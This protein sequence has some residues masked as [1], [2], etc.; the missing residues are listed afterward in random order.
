[1]KKIKVV[2]KKSLSFMLILCMFLACFRGLELS[3]AE[4]TGNQ[5]GTGTGTETEEDKF[6]EGEYV[7]R[8]GNKN[9]SEANSEAIMLTADSAVTLMCADANGEP[10]P[11]SVP[12]GTTMTIDWS[13]TNDN[14]FMAEGK[15]VTATVNTKNGCQLTII[16]IGYDN[17]NVSIKIENAEG[18]TTLIQS[19]KICVPIR[20][21]G[22]NIKNDSPLSDGTYGLGYEFET[23]ETKG[24]LYLSG[25]E[26]LRDADPDNDKYNKYLLMLQTED[27]EYKYT[28]GAGNDVILNN[29]SKESDIENSVDLRNFLKEKITW[30]SSNNNVA[31]VEY[32][33]ITGI[34]AGV[35]VITAS[36][37]SANNDIQSVSIRVVVTPTGYLAVNGASNDYKSSFSEITVTSDFTIATNAK[38]ATDLVWNIYRVDVKNNEI[39]WSNEVSFEDSGLDVTVYSTSGDIRVRNAKAGTYHITARVSKD[40]DETNTYTPKFQ[41]YI[42]VPVTFPSAPVYMNVNDTYNIPLNAMVPSYDWFQYVSSD[43]TT[44]DVSNEGIVEALKKGEASIDVT[45]VSTPQLKEYFSNNILNDP[46]LLESVLP[47]QSTVKIKIID[48]IYLNYSSAVIYT[49]GTLT[50]KSYTTSTGQVTWS[51]ADPSIATVSESGVV[52]GINPGTVLITATQQTGELTKTAVCRITVLEGVTSITLT[53]EEAELSVGEVITINADVKPSLTGVSLHWV[54]SDPEILKILNTTDLSV[55][56]EGKSG[57]W[58]TITAINQENVVVG[59]SKIFVSEPIKSITLSQTDVMVPLSSEWLQLE[60][61]IFPDA[62]KEQEVVWTSSDKTIATVDN[63]TVVF[64]KAGIVTITVTSKEDATISASC[65]VT[66][67]KEVTGISLDNTSLSMFVGE[68]YRLQCVITPADAHELAVEWSSTNNSVA[69]VDSNGLVSAKGIGSAII[70]VRTKDGGFTATCMVE[71]GKTATAV[72]LDV[73]DLVMRVGEDYYL[74][75][76]VTP[77]DATDATLTYTTS[78]SSVVTVSKSGKV[79]AKKTG[80]A[81]ITVRTRSGSLAMCTVTVLDNVSGIK[82]G[83]SNLDIYV[84]DKFQLTY[85]ISPDNVYDSSVSWYS[86]NPSVASVDSKGVVTGKSAGQTV[87]YVTTTDGAYYATCSVT[88][89]QKVESIKMDVEKLTMNKGD[90]YYLEP[91]FT[92]KDTTETDVK[93]YIFDGSIITIS[94]NGK[95]TAKK[96]GTTLVSATAENGSI[97]Y[98]TVEVL[99]AVT[100]VQMSSSSEIIHIGDTLQLKAQVVPASATEQG[101]KWTSTDT[102]VATVDQTGLVSGI[103]GGVA[104]VICETADGGYNDFC[105]V[106]VDEKVTDI[107]LNY[108]E[109]RLGLNDTFQLEATITGERATN[110]EVQWMSA[111]KRI[112]SV[113]ENGKVRGLVKGK[114]EIICMA[115][116]G[117]GAEAVCEVEVCTLVT[118]IELDV[119]TLTLIKGKSY[120]LDANISPSNATYKTPIWTSSD[121]DIVMVDKKGVITGLEEGTAIITATADDSGKESALCY[122]TVI[123]PVVAKSISVTSSELV[124]VPGESKNVSYTV[125]PSNFTEDVSWTCD[126]TSVATVDPQTGKI[127]AKNTGI[128]NITVM[129]PSGAKATIKVYV[130]GLSRTEVTLKQYESLLIRLQIDGAEEAGVSVRWDVEDQGIAEVQGGRVTAKALGTTKVYAV[131]NGRKLECKVTVIKN[132]KK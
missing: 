26:V 36:I 60:A 42:T 41:C 18:T 25:N 130:V 122:V 120:A 43:I 72:R 21:S 64:K 82:L 85:T 111:N 78:N 20:L 83:T 62:A 66:I 59:S 84:A 93:Y 91:I 79:T 67:T 132:V 123:D 101:M 109:Y 2:L 1:M 88:V 58:A 129:T 29:F 35:A 74:T 118:D 106:T 100:G 49:G 114:T 112:C 4:E 116:D 9:Y 6:F 68:T 110:K 40:H 98:F 96:A 17:L 70:I 33:V 115:L 61:E 32:G 80:H 14:V 10:K 76:T 125:K 108:T 95:V 128:A 31:T 86:F 12:T 92:P 55:N 69:S 27:L 23:D 71:V 11:I 81:I 124:M 89:E 57:G 103:A 90:Y 13:T 7:L 52:K 53:P 105:I 22:N 44:A 94:K 104:V 37:T 45:R 28:D 102:S 126:N 63:G 19:W 113:D 5:E 99:E 16:G 46:N 119:K 24:T 47:S 131:V 121:S 65:K 50:L 87:I 51:S 15:Q 107:A 39:L 73:S 3:F 38:K 75:A 127:I 56:I 117:S 97:F 30:T 48:S 8:I 54:S 34:N 77:K